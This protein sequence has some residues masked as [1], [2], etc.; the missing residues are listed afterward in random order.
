MSYVNA[1]VPRHGSKTPDENVARRRI[2]E[3]H[4]SMVA[5]CKGIVFPP[6]AVA[7]SQLGSH[8]PAVP[9]IPGPRGEPQCVRVD[10]LD[11]L[12]IPLREAEQELGKAVVGIRPR[13][14]IQSGNASVKPKSAARRA[15]G[16]ALG[17]EVVDPAVVVLQT[18]AQ[19][20]PS[21][22]PAEV[23]VSHILIIPEDEGVAGVGVPE[24]GP[25]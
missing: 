11:D 8:L 19:I 20:V 9:R 12:A 3:L 23:R 16:P 13:P 5:N 6:H 4:A 21:L 24:I 10:V 14:A 1:I 15:K 25:A 18:E 17:L 7:E 2:K 22:S